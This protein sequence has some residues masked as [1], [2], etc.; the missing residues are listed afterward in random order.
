MTI[1]RMTSRQNIW[2]MCVN[3]QFYTRGDISAYEEMLDSVP[4]YDELTDDKLVDIATDIYY[5]SEKRTDLYSKSEILENLIYIIVN[6][7][8]YY[9][10]EM[11]G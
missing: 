9:A 2:Q 8:C 3:H 6:E 4:D 1:T 7:A 10:V 5:H 11:E